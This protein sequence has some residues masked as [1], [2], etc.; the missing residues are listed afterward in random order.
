MQ[1]HSV[2]SGHAKSHG[3]DTW[4]DVPRGTQ[5]LGIG[6]CK[7]FMVLQSLNRRDP[8]FLQTLGAG[9]SH[10]KWLMEIYHWQK[11]KVIGFFA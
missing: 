10:L 5:L 7:A 11:E 4:I 9:L 1:I 8:K 2:N 6:K 3:P